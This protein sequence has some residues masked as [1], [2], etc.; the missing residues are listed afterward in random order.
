MIIIFK[1]APPHTVVTSGPLKVTDSNR[2]QTLGGDS[3]TQLA[4]NCSFC[5]LLIFIDAWWGNYFPS[6]YSFIRAYSSVHK[7][8]SR[9]LSNGHSGDRTRNPTG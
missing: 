9:Y 7:A 3:G 2:Y 6:F 1:H 5:I 4:E 8:C